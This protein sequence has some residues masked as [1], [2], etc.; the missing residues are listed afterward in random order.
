MPGPG[1]SE[2]VNDR[3]GEKI[4]FLPSPPT[5][6]KPE[7][8]VWGD[9]PHAHGASFTQWGGLSVENPEPVVCSDWAEVVNRDDAEDRG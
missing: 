9:F 3:V 5:F 8:L 7:T 1:V 4:F 2:L 6:V